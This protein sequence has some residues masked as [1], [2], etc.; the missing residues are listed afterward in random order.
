MIE[1]KRIQRITGL[2]I[3]EQEM[4]FRESAEASLDPITRNPEQYRSYI[5][6]LPDDDSDEKR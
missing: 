2:T 3:H 4:A 6:S 5:D 1:V